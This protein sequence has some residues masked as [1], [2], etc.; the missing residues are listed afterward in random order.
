MN[1]LLTSPSMRRLFTSVALSVPPIVYINDNIVTIE[2]IHDDSMQP[3]LQKGDLVL[4]R[5]IELF[6]NHSLSVDDLNQSER[7]DEDDET[8]DSDSSSPSTYIDHQDEKDLS[9]LI[10]I[11]RHNQEE[12][13]GDWWNFRPLNC[14]PGNVVLL[15]N[16]RKFKPIDI[17]A[18]RL[19]A[20]GGQKVRSFD[21]T[22]W[23][24]K[25]NLSSISQLL[26]WQRLSC[27]TSAS[28]TNHVYRHFVI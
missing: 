20:L 21:G 17:Q 24:F 14:L 27:L 6:L 5:R 16:P 4:V 7:L 12:G 28:N 11:R 19:V 3:A 22:K 15:K 13:G 2:T 25:T 26:T 9:N 18:R 10:D 8:N 1:H 23:G